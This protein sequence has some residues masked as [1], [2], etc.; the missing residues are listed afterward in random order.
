MPNLPAAVGEGAAVFYAATEVSEA[1]RRN[2]DAVLKGEAYQDMDKEQL[3]MVLDEALNLAQG[4]VS[5]CNEVGDRVGAKY[6]NGKV[7]LPEGFAGAYKDLADG[8]WISATNAD[9][10]TTWFI[11]SRKT[12]LRVFLGSGSRPS[13]I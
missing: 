8:G 7:E 5:A 10:G 1:Q 6:A 12:S 4:S 2:M 11:S 3:G 9:Q 13:V